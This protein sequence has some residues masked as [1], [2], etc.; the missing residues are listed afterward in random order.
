MVITS[1]CVRCGLPVFILSANIFAPQEKFASDRGL[2][3]SSDPERVQ[4]CRARHIEWA[5]F[6][7]PST[8][9]GVLPLLP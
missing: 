4:S 3:P 2:A 7:Q 9:F 6:L 5:L 1:E 8:R